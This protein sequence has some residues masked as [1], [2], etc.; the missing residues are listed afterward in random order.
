[1][2]LDYSAWDHIY[3]SDDEDATSPFV[4]APSLFRMRHRTRLQKSSEIQQRGE[5]LRNNF[6][7]CRRLLDDA[8]QRLRALEEGR[9][10]GDAGEERE[11]ELR[12]AEAE[13]SK[14]KEDE[15][16]FEDLVEEHMREA[17]RMPWNVDTISKEG[18]SKSVLNIKPAA[19]Q[20]RRGSFVEKYE[21][22]IKHFGM[23]RRWDDS[24]RYLSDHPH[25]ACEETARHLVGVCIDLEVDEA[26]VM[27]FILDLARAL[28]LDPRGC[29]GP[30]FSR[31]K[32]ADKA[33]RD[34][35][36]QELELLRER[37]R[38]CAQARVEEAAKELE[39]EERQR[40]LGP[41]GLDPVE[42]Y[43]SLPEELQRSF[44]KK[45]I[46][47]LQEAINKLDPEE[48]KYHFKRCIDS[49]LW[50]PDSGEHNDDDDD[51]DEEEDG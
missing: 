28:K 45:N 7:E 17:K 4:D 34:A 36:D 25:L 38:S 46:Q 51:D 48:G 47:M 15:E 18:F 13:V 26:I 40:R 16:R 42:V 6:A 21:E 2:S 27:Q 20:E 24:Q 44:D 35:F 29:V 33:Y 50:V 3:V 37:V 10:A 1:M 32:M 5:D 43:E 19:E 9:R 11:A 49:G 30:F 23:L 41:G 12:K 14:L 31:V 39:E 22:E 8:Q